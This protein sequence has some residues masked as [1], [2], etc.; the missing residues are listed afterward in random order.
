[1]AESFTAATFEKLVR[2]KYA[3]WTKTSLGPVGRD[4]VLDT[5]RELINGDR[6]KQYGDAFDTH[7]RI[8]EMWNALAPEGAPLDASTVALMMICVKIIRAT[9]TPEKADSW[10]DI[11]GYAALGAEFARAK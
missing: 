8:A 5:A 11:A 9:R 10:I 4:E 7:E 6:A 2:D 1:L 3:A